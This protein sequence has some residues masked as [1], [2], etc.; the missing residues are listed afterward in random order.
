MKK[1][2]SLIL[3]LMGVL[4]IAQ[5]T[6][7]PKSISAKATLSG[8]GAVNQASDT[9]IATFSDTNMVLGYRTIS[10]VLSQSIVEWSAGTYSNNTL[11][12]KNIN[13][14]QYIFR[15]TADSN[16]TEPFL[17]SNMLAWSPPPYG[18][19]YVGEWAAG[20]YVTGNIVSRNGWAY[21]CLVNNSTDP[22]LLNQIDWVK[23][24]QWEGLYNSGTIYYNGYVVRDGSNNVYLSNFDYNQY[25]LNYGIVSKWEV[26]NGMPKTI[27]YWGDSLTT[28]IYSTGNGSYPMQVSIASGTNADI[29]GFPGETSTQIKDRM[30]LAPETWNNTTVICVG[31]NNN[32]DPTTVK[33]DIAAMVALLKHG[34]YIIVGILEGTS[35]NPAGIRALNN[36]LH[37]LYPNNFFDVTDYLYQIYN[38]S[39][40]Q[41]VTDHANGDIAWSLRSDYIHLN[42]LGYYYFAKGVLSKMNTLL[43]QEYQYA[44]NL[45]TG[46]LRITDNTPSNQNTIGGIAAYDKTSNFVF[47]DGYNY[48]TNTSIPQ[49]FGYNALAEIYLSWNSG[50]VFLGNLPSYSSGNAGMLVRNV[51]GRMET[52]PSIGTGIVPRE[53]ANGILTSSNIFS[54]GSIASV[55]STSVE[56]GYPFQANGTGGIARF[57]NL[58]DV[59]LYLTRLNPNTILL[60][61]RSLVNEY[62]QVA[63][64]QF[65]VSSS[66]PSPTVNNEIAVFDGRVKVSE[67]TLSTDVPTFGQVQNLTG[68]QQVSGNNYTSGVPLL[69]LAG[70]TTTLANN[71]AT[72]NIT[73]QLPTGVTSFVNTTNGKITPENDGD[74]YIVDIR[75]KATSSSNDGVI[76]VGIDIG[77]VMGIIRQHTVNIRKGIGV[78]QRVALSFPVFSGATF[79]AN[80]GEVK[81][82]S[83]VGDTSI[84]DVTFVVDRVHKAK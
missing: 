14:Q 58:S 64:K 43:G 18:G 26:V 66:V 59:S 70:N 8:P 44:K 19:A 17:N 81:V 2:F 6:N 53:G 72:S 38:L 77:G 75:F 48:K 76:D 1:L 30:Y 11:V 51:S 31:R 10:D 27:S 9:K 13:N 22:V 36:D 80:G 60:H 56:S 50:K 3:F 65:I 63:T 23:L 16:T 12:T 21:Y 83:V 35:D 57:G 82:T 71:G 62:L 84:Y 54:D 41:D 79:I 28:S 52:A 4:S 49:Y 37:A 29:H 61:S 74:F 20:A 7:F 69:I 46:G 47:Y 45:E 25:A 34:R 68:W 32:G 55:G 15:S 67:A 40:P 33:A 39:I 78:E 73:T 42:N 24:G 5:P